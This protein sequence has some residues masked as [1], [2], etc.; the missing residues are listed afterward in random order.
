MFQK[1]K[2][3]KWNN[4]RTLSHHKKKGETVKQP[5]PGSLPA[6]LAITGVCNVNFR[7]KWSSLELIT[8]EK[9][10]ITFSIKL[11]RC[12]FLSLIQL[13]TFLY[14]IVCTHGLECGILP[15][16]NC[17]FQWQIHLWNGFLCVEHRSGCTH[18]PPE[19]SQF[20]NAR[21]KPHRLKNEPSHNVNGWKCWK[22]WLGPPT[23]GGRIRQ[24]PPSREYPKACALVFMLTLLRNLLHGSTRGMSFGASED[25]TCKVW[26]Q[27]RFIDEAL[28]DCQESEVVACD[29]KCC[30][31]QVWQESPS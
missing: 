21:L 3:L 27:T 20:Q 15:T 24:E 23:R 10:Q 26:R 2:Q 4:G 30:P 6:Q 13:K 16:L 14:F 9:F 11:K 25:P 1:L 28:Q 29:W 31:V 22:R 18:F 17:Y 19:T 5:P 7:S 8:N 12:I